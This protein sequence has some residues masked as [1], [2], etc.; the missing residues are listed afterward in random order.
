MCS[1]DLVHRR[2][3]ADRG[4]GVAFGELGVGIDEAFE[5]VGCILARGDA[6]QRGADG[7]AGGR[8]GSPGAG[9]ADGGAGA[10]AGASE[11]SDGEN[12]SAG[13]GSLRILA[14]RL[15]ST[16]P[17]PTSSRVVRPFDSSRDTD[18]YHFTVWLIW[19]VISA[20]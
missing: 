1:S 11:G 2:H 4:G 13:I 16:S 7:A 3:G 5:D 17:G 15:V 19:R 20:A 18:S 8:G 6:V 9:D 14:N 10:G 12:A